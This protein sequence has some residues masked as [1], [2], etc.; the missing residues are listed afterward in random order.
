MISLRRVTSCNGVKDDW[1]ENMVM[2][3]DIAMEE[4]RKIK[5]VMMGQSSTTISTLASWGFNLRPL[6][7]NKEPNIRISPVLRSLP[8]AKKSIILAAAGYSV[9]S[10]I[11]RF[12]PNFVRQLSDKG[13]RNCSNI[14]VASPSWSKPPLSPWRQFIRCLKRFFRGYIFI[15]II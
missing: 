14:G 6:Y 10:L 7:P 13:I 5:K 8:M 1:S 4:A 2:M 12:P 15:N 9:S 3:V 11:F